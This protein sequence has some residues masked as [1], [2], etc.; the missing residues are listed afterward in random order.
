VVT[1]KD[2]EIAWGYQLDRSVIALMWADFRRHV[3]DI[4]IVGW[5]SE[6]HGRDFRMPASAISEAVRIRLQA[7]IDGLTR[8]IADLGI[9]PDTIELATMPELVKPTTTESE[10]ASAW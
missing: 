6:G 9:T 5:D 3:G 10:V 7:D 2:A 4:R 8:K 1:I